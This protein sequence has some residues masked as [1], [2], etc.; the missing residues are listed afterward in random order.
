MNLVL[1]KNVGA[2]RCWVD[3]ARELQPF[4]VD[5]VSRTSSF[6]VTT[7]QLAREGENTTSLSVTI[8]GVVYFSAMEASV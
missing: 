8:S 4:F 1:Q 5:V 7:A 6:A 2:Y 3:T